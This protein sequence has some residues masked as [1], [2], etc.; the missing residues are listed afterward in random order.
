MGD[1]VIAFPNPD[2]E[3][4]IAKYGNLNTKEVFE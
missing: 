2:S 3:E 1:M 4:A